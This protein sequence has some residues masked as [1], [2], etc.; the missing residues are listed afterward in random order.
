M[1]IK[2]KSFSFK[3]MM[4][5]SIVILIFSI[6]VSA[7]IGRKISK[8]TE[9]KAYA[10]SSNLAYKYGTFIKQ[11]MENTLQTTATLASTID[12]IMDY[13]NVNRTQLDYMQIAALKGNKDVNSI[14]VIADN[15]G[16]DGNDANFAGKKGQINN[17]R[18]VTFFVRNGGEIINEPIE[19]DF[20]PG[21]YFQ[22][23]K[24]D[25][26]PIMFD[27]YFDTV[28]GK[29]ILF[30][31]VLSPI[32][33]KDKFCG[34]VAADITLESFQNYIMELTKDNPD[35]SVRLV[36]YN[37]T[38]ITNPNKELLGKPVFKDDNKEKEHI[39]S[40]IQQGKN[41]EEFVYSEYLNEEAYR[42]YAPVFVGNVKT[43]WSLIVDTPVS[44]IKKEANMVKKYTVII[45]IILLVFLLI[46]IYI[47]LKK[48]TK[49][50]IKVSDHLKCLSTGNFME[51][52]PEEII[53]RND[54]FKVLGDSISKM[55]CNIK[56]ILIKIN[57]SFK[58][59]D[60]AFEGVAHMADQSNKTVCEVSKSID[61]ISSSIVGECNS[62]EI[63]SEK[64][65]SLG[66]KINDSNEL[67]FDVFNIS[68]DTSKLTND[69][70]EIMKLLDVRTKESNEKTLEI[71]NVIQDTNEY[72]NSAGKIIGLINSI[73]AQTNLLALNASIEAARAG[74]SGKGFAVVAEEIR[75]LSEETSKATNDIKILLDNIQ[76]KSS[77]ATSTMN[78]FSEIIEEQNKTISNTN[79]IFN[80]TSQLLERFVD[81]INKLKKYTMEVQNNKD[82]IIDSLCNMSVTTQEAVANTEQI[83]ASSEEQ[84]AGLEGISTYTEN[85]KNLIE[86]LK[87]EIEKF[88][89]S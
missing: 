87:K 30:T 55:Q 52:I 21:K 70:I 76:G 61:E 4:V 22:N 74:S 48:V 47:V 64:A 44:K 3:V 6:S 68:S 42:I 26:Q 54:E 63:L 62:I 56:D 2:F 49:P 89:V 36:A 84:L 83:A 85:T 11:R 39:M 19:S 82:E 60:E 23:M 77:E 31:S 69:G 43:P 10:E 81:K 35:I 79:E 80:N 5:V 46:L 14:Y 41:S 13:G 66:D 50:L 20:T 12:G 8:I 78:E 28:A 29:K 67:V 38:Y 15:N 40:I 25:K 34:L 45:T 86:N 72:A 51:E 9:E 57:T 1:T 16:I 75:K 17:G 18:Y 59:V 7:F 24:S 65:N 33:H 88:K 58:E 53:K 71:A 27:P 73:A 37:G 32:V